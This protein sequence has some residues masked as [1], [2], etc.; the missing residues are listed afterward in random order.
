VGREPD[1]VTAAPGAL[2]V[3]VANEGDN[4]ISVI[5][6]RTRTL[7]K[8]IPVGPRPR[9]I[10]ASRDGS[11]VFFTEFGTNKLGVIDSE[12]DTLLGEV[13]ASRNASAR[14]RGIWIGT[15]TIY[16]T[17]EVMNE[18]SVIS[19]STGA[20]KF[21]IPLAGRPSEVV[22]T[23]D[24]KTAYVSMPSSNKVVVLNMRTRSVSSELTIAGGPD[25]LRLTPRIPAGPGTAGSRVLIVGLSGTPAQVALVDTKSSV[26][27]TATVNLGRR[28]CTHLHFR[29][30]S[31]LLRRPQLGRRGHVAG[32]GCGPRQPGRNRRRTLSLSRW[33]RSARNLLRRSAGR[34]QPE[35]CH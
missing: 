9:H 27:R 17:N 20:I 32:G 16:V 6:T 22:V 8:T 23:P 24:E 35:H 15:S 5:S 28:C 33:R 21:A 1:A 14:P 13:P 2:K 18:I 30:R 3:Y 26:V 7:L 4:T 19:G 11:L 25:T 12:E 29:R 34:R 10:Q 31:A